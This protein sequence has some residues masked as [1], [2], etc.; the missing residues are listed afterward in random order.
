MC[1]TVILLLD[2]AFLPE[3]LLQIFTQVTLECHPFPTDA[4]IMKDPVVPPPLVQ[5]GKNTLQGGT[6][7][8]G[9]EKCVKKSRM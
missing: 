7:W 4:L 2:S 8:L 9:N 6:R 5:Y 3:K 1:V